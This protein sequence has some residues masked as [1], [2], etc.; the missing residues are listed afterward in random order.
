MVPINVLQ[1]CYNYNSVPQFW[2]KTIKLS[3]RVTVAQ[4]EEEALRTLLDQ[5]VHRSNPRPG[6]YDIIISNLKPYCLLQYV[7]INNLPQSYIAGLCQVRRH[8]TVTGRNSGGWWI[9]EKKYLLCFRITKMIQLWHFTQEINKKWK[10]E[11]KT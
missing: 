7:I 8:I 9:I 5:K 10:Q 1:K 3:N 4:M 11:I 6:S 2:K